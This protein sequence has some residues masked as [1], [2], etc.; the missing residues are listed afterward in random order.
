MPGS[1]AKDRGGRAT[2]HDHGD[3]NVGQGAAEFWVHDG[4]LA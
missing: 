2:E 3:R 4:W 1:Q